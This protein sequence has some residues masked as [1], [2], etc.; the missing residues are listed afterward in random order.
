MC[1]NRIDEGTDPELPKTYRREAAQH[2]LIGIRGLSLH[3]TSLERAA[4]SIQ[5]GPA[6]DNLATG[7]LKSA[8]PG[9]YEFLVTLA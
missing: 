9:N 4:R 3:L 2:Q 6:S 1:Y 7:N 8:V 5:R